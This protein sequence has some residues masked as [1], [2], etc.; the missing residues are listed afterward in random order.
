ML[1]NTSLKKAQ[2]A[3]IFFLSIFITVTFIWHGVFPLLL[4]FEFW[5][6]KKSARGEKKNKVNSAA[7]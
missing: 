2:L 5:K 3:T 7:S 4:I 1:H 6:K